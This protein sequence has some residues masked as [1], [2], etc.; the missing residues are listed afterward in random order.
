MN[1]LFRTDDSAVSNLVDRFIQTHGLMEPADIMI[2]LPRYQAPLTPSELR[3]LTIAINPLRHSD[4]R[5]IDIF[6]DV[7]RFILDRLH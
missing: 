1:N 5:G 7:L 3:Q 2:V 4:S 6:R